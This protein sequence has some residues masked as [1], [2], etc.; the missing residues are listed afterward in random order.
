VREDFYQR[1][2]EGAQ[3]AI[4]IYVTE[5]QKQAICQQEGLGYRLGIKNQKQMFYPALLKLSDAL[6]LGRF[7]YPD[8]GRV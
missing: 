1:G 4:M 2:V 6:H 5:A 3:R 7:L 8:S